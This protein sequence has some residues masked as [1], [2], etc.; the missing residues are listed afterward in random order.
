MNRETFLVA[1]LGQFQPTGTE[2]T[3][4]DHEL[5]FELTLSPTTILY[6]RV[7]W[8]DKSDRFVA[9][10]TTEDQQDPEKFLAA[11]FLAE[12]LANVVLKS[13]WIPQAAAP[14]IPSVG[15][16]GNL[17][18]STW[19]EPSESGVEAFSTF[20]AWAIAFHSWIGVEPEWWQGGVADTL[21]SIAS[22][23][24]IDHELGVRWSEQTWS[25]FGTD[26]VAGVFEF[27]GDDQLLYRGS[28]PEDA[29]PSYATVAITQV[30]PRLLQNNPRFF[31]SVL[32]LNSILIGIGTG[33][34]IDGQDVLRLAACF[35]KTSADSNWHQLPELVATVT[36][37]LDSD[38]SCRDQLADLCL[39][40][41]WLPDEL[42]I[43]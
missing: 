7:V 26:R 21:R 24:G 20:L 17:N 6:A 32:C 38:S 33:L 16:I 22:W 5:C 19:L 2:V 23:E 10:V 25:E 37:I 15:P 12:G 34:G 39:N 11:E 41:G 40:A 3:G 27:I 9:T 1:C 4:G 43:Q 36:D 42:I 35:P 18:W 8:D 29:L 31:E 13:R 14:I 28:F 30:G